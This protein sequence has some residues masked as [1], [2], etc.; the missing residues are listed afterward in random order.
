MLRG[1]TPR[2]MAP[3]G[4]ASRG[5]A[6]GDGSTRECFVGQRLGWWPHRGNA[7]RGSAPGGWPTLECITGNAR[8]G[9]PPWMRGATSWVVGPCGAPVPGG[10]RT[11]AM[12]WSSRGL[13]VQRTSSCH[14]RGEPWCGGS[15]PDVCRACRIGRGALAQWHNARHLSDVP[16]GRHSQT[17]PWVRDARRTR[18]LERGLLAT[19][20]GV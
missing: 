17:P 4:N 20:S 11:W 6:S 2:V 10:F 16:P 9:G 12:G 14:M 3:P 15:M 5:N 7:S 8:V 1:A 18:G 13:G 19:R